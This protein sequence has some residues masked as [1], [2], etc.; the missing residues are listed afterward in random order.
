M[1]K[2][3]GIYLTKSLIICQAQVKNQVK[4]LIIVLNVVSQ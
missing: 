3:E 1:S 4:E 2:V